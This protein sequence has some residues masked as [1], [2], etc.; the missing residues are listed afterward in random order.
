MADL[1]PV[2]ARDCACPGSPHGDDGDIVYLKSHL[3]MEGGLLAEQQMQSAVSIEIKL[4]GNPESPEVVMRAMERLQ[5]LWA[6]TF[7]THGAA[8][9]NL[10]DA[11]GSPQPFDVEVIM[12]DWGFARAVAD[13]ATELYGDSVMDPFLTAS[14]SASQTGPTEDSTSRRRASKRKSGKSSSRDTS[15]GSTPSSD[16]TGGDTL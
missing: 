9:W 2:R 5:L 6:R 7:L 4:A 14:G 1:V 15:V 16:S 10:V 11:E 8:G 13:K 12:A 3:P